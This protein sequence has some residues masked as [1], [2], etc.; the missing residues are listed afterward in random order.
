MVAAAREE[1]SC[2]ENRTFPFVCACR[3]SVCTAGLIKVSRGVW[4]RNFSF[5]RTTHV[6]SG[7]YIYQGTIRILRNTHTCAVH[8]IRVR[9]HTFLHI[10]T[11][12]EYSHGV[13]SGNKYLSVE[14]RCL[15]RLPR[16]SASRFRF[17]GKCLTFS[18]PP[19]S[20]LLLL[21]DLVNDSSL[22][23]VLSLCPSF[24]SSKERIFFVILYLF[25]SR[26]RSRKCH[27][28]FSF[29]WL[30]VEDFRLFAF[31]LTCSSLESPEGKKQNVRSSR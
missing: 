7:V 10:R 20:A 28:L 5:S 12:Y 14:A 25:L 23:D 24:P 17:Q 29:F 2:R 30:S 31:C 6:W 1:W 22:R 21:S 8:Q 4:R 16:L 18:S 3:C 9:I 15:S 19:P 13:V 26:R 27:F 11:G